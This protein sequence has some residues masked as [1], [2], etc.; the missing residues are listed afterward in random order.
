MNILVIAPDYPDQKR[1]GAVF[2]KQLVDEFAK[3]GNHCV[4][5][6]PYSITN[7][8][9]FYTKGVEYL[10]FDKGSVRVYR[11]NVLSIS[12]YKIGKFS[13]DYFRQKAIAKTLKKLHKECFDFVYGHF[14]ISGY[15][16]FQYARQNNI[17]LFVATGESVI[18]SIFKE[19]IYKDYLQYVRGVICVSTKNKDES[20]NLG[21]TSADKCIVAPNA[22]DNKLFKSLNKAECRKKLQFPQDV[23]LVGT[24]GW[25]TERKGQVRVAKA[26]E[27]IN[28]EKTQ[29]VFIGDG[30]ARPE[31]KHVLF[32]SKVM[33]DSVPEYLNA[34]DVYVL[35]TRNEGCCNSIIEAM[36]CGLPIISSD[37]PFNYDVL[38]K[39][40][41][42]LIEPDDI[43]QIKDAVLKLRDNEALRNNM[44]KSSLSKASDLT[45]EKRAETILDFIKSRL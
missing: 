45:I 26:I 38:D 29:S 28:D 44:G 22:I 43:G 11:P 14:W 2:L 27:E 40:N 36:A 21:M 24:V 4:V 19:E 13:S 17:P 34:L 37:R 30:E 6:S 3:Q 10:D 23:F 31:G 16:A 5:I 35:P 7:N 18:P 1:N 15:E 41:S 42:V 20:V 25:F 9:S 12:N 32:C 8:K 39:S 33:H